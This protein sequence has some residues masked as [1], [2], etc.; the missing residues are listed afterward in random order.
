MNRKGLII[1]ITTVTLLLG[2]GGWYTRGWWWGS[3]P[4]AQKKTEAKSDKGKAAANDKAKT[5]AD[6]Q[7][8]GSE[9]TARVAAAQMNNR[10]GGNASSK[11]PLRAGAKSEAEDE[12]PLESDETETE[13]EE[14]APVRPTSKFN[15]KFAKPTEEEPTETDPAETDPAATDPSASEVPAETQ[16]AEGDENADAMKA[17]ETTEEDAPAETSGSG[18]D[19]NE[20]ER[21]TTTIPEENTEPS[22]D[23]PTESDTGAGKPPSALPGRRDL[24]RAPPLRSEEETTE[25]SAK[26]LPDEEVVRI[27][28]PKRA[29]NS[30]AVRPEPVISR[31]A[32]KPVNLKVAQPQERPPTLEETP[33]MGAATSGSRLMDDG[34]SELTNVISQSITKPQES[35]GDRRLEGEQS[36]PL[37]LTKSAPSEVSVGRPAVFETRVKNNG[38]A[39]SRQVIVMD[40]VPRGARLIDATPKFSQTAEGLLIWNLGDLDPGQEAVIKMQLMPEEEGEIGSVAS[41]TNQIQASARAVST[42]PQLQVEH[43]GPAKALVGDLVTFRIRIHNPGTGVARGV[44]IEEDVPRGLAH[45]SGRQIEHEIGDLLPGRSHE[46]DLDLTAAEAGLVSNTIRVRAEGDLSAEHTTELEVL[47]PQLVTEIKGPKRRYLDREAKYEIRIANPGTA[48]AKSVEFTV[49]LPTGLKYTSADSSGRYDP[50][51]HAVTWKI[52]SLPAGEEGVVQLA[53]LS[54]TSGQ[55]SLRVAARAESGLEASNELA[56]LVEAAPETT[57]TVHDSSDQVEV[58]AEATY[59]IVVSNR[60]TRADAQVRIE[61]TLPPEMQVVSAEGPAAHTVDGQRV[62]FEPLGRLDPKSEVT[63]KIK[64]KALSAAQDPRVVRVQATSSA[65]TTPVSREESTLI[66]EDR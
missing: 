14:A 12:A 16:G 59:E 9:P 18:A 31:E 56:V 66:Y 64:I 11:P 24:T 19:T 13:T 62:I 15:S 61:A 52:A 46:I 60:G 28:E 32:T 38:S 37:S 5:V 25:E 50:K 63:Y 33:R 35:P 45:D 17:E 6:G 54:M 4:T 42:R 8:G 29:A 23:E 57:F 36:A 1:A 3:K 51:R 44:R 49:Q 2:V 41:V 10:F 26:E 39:I 22:S 40:R 58:G 7:M 27:Q 55:Q 21:E 43:V 65:L 47:A 48:A 53:V 20:S 34:R 30:V